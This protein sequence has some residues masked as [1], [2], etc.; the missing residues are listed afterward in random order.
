MGLRSEW[1][2]ATKSGFPSVTRWAQ[3]W[4]QNSARQ[5]G[6]LT[7]Q[8]MALQSGQLLVHPREQPTAQQ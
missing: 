3:P 7:A 5:M 6:P 2:L 1:S 8:R 4:A